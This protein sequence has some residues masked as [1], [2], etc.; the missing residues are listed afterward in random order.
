MINRILIALTLLSTCAGAQTLNVRQIDRVVDVRQNS[1]TP[2]IEWYNGES[3]T[4]NVLVRRANEPVNLPSDTVP[5][6]KAWL[7]N[8]L[9]TLY[10]N[11]T[12]TLVAS[13]GNEVSVVLA[14]H[15]ANLPAGT[16]ISSVQLWQGTNYMGIGAQ[17]PLRVIWSP[18]GESIAYVGTTNSP[19]IAQDELRLVET[20]SNHYA[21]A[22]ATIY[23][24]RE[25]DTNAIAQLVLASN[26]LY[27]VSTNEQARRISADAALSNAIADIISGSVSNEVDPIWSA[28][29]NS[30]LTTA[31][32][33]STYATGSPIYSL[34]GYATGTP[35]YAES[36]PLFVASS[37]ALLTKAQAAL[38]YATGTP[39]YAV[40]GLGTD[41][42]ARAWALGASN[43]ADAAYVLAANAA[44]GTPIYSVAG[45][46]TGTPI[47]SVAGLAT[48]TPIYSLAGLATGAPIYSVAGLAT[49]T[50]LYV[51]NNPSLS[52]LSND[53]SNAITTGS[54]ALAVANA[55]SNAAATARGWGNHATSGYAVQGGNITGRWIAVGSGVNISDNAFVGGG[56]DT[57]ALGSFSF[58]GGGFENEA[59]GAYSTVV[60]GSS[61]R[62]AAHYSFVGGGLANRVYGN[63]GTIIGGAG[64]TIYGN[65]ATIGGGGLNEA[66]GDYSS[67]PGG[68]DNKASTYSFAAGVGAKATNYGSVV[69][70][71]PGTTND[72]F[73]S[74]GDNSFNVRAVGGSYFLSPDFWIQDT[75]GN[76]I[77]RFSGT[78]TTISGSLN[79]TGYATTSDVLTAGAV[80]TNAQIAASN[81]QTTASAATNLAYAIGAG[82]TNG[83]LNVG[84][85]ATNAQQVASNGLATAQAAQVQASNINAGAWSQVATGAVNMA[86]SPVTN[87]AYIAF[88]TN[89][90]SGTETNAIG[91]NSGSPGWMKSPGSWRV[92]ANSENLSSLGIQTTAGFNGSITNYARITP[93]GYSFPS[94]WN[95]SVGQNGDLVRIGTNMAFKSAGVWV[96]WTVITNW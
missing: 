5:V 62:A 87:A 45:L 56:L 57:Y 65:Y 43:R 10:I 88:G 36:D 26:S 46:A 32:A 20:N 90:L 39:I 38:L 67:I 93:T 29:S 51:E 14:A 30:Y 33:Q 55:A 68:I 75:N 1:S 77:A 66:E 48:G 8:D 12:G 64:N 89:T 72:T 85:V 19:W 9:N 17:G 18:A 53:V 76:T 7:S 69:F 60:G 79:L 94:A 82:A 37:N 49:G 2:M 58:V 86:N 71:S 83:I 44:T 6:W 74:R 95:D 22:T 52:A 24:N 92:F 16:Y 21:S 61:H 91:I 27:S 35:V 31:A 59:T 4:Y 11:A 54:L 47:Y 15:Q 42:T 50:P 81:A 78:N 96:R 34:T 28:V 73:G 63:Y 80:A 23:I 3:V 84:L 70:S 25:Q 40:S 41:T 13:G